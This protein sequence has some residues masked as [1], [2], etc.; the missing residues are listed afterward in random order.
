MHSIEYQSIKES[1]NA[2]SY[3]MGCSCVE[4]WGTRAL[5]VVARLVLLTPWC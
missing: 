3:G 1:P 5:F 2:V 4:I